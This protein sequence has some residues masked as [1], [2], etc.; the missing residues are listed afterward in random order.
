MNPYPHHSI[1]KVI[2]L[3]GAWEFAFLGALDPDTLNLGTIAFTERMVVPQ[4]FDATPAY[5]GKRGVAVYRN[6]LRIPAGTIA[7]LRFG[8]VGMWCRVLIDGQAVAEHS[9]GYTEFWVDVPRSQNEQRELLVVVDNQ[10]SFERSPLQE[11]YFDWYHYGGITRPVYLHLLP[12]TYLRHATVRVLDWCTGDIEVAL[13]LGGGAVESLALKASI[14]STSIFDNQVSITDQKAVIRLQ[15]PD[16]QPWSPEHPNLHTLHLHTADDDMEIRFG[17]R[18]VRTH[19]HEILLNDVPVKLKGICRHEFHPQFGPAQPPALMIADLQQVRQLGANFIRGSH[20]PQDQRFLD[21]CDELGFLVWEEAIGWQQ[22]L[23]HF[24]DERYLAAQE[25]CIDEMIAAS[26]NHPSVILWGILNEA[27]TDLPESR[28]VFERLLGRLRKLDP[29]RLITYADNRRENS[30]CLDLV[31]VVS[32]NMYPGW[33]HSELEDVLPFIRKSLDAA[34]KLAGEIRP[35]IISEIGADAIPGWH[36]AHRKR[37]T[38]EYQADLL[39]I[40]CG[41]MMRNEQIT[42]ISIWHFFDF[43]VTELTQRVLGRPRSYNHKGLM[44]EYRRPKQAFARMKAI[45]EQS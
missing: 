14:D 17:L 35:F 16:P 9:G 12:E 31:D 45:F 18:S 26:I 19:G 36:D 34:H 24:T 41:E 38:E 5:A 39:Q 15:T 44:D 28:P 25:Q 29:T 20:Y 40:A 11:E 2:D 1:R 33:Y 10:F 30:L 6:S 21:L 3:S 7:R 13:D 42:G 23:R 8:G 32:F 22:A 37:W 43:R 4:A 27:C